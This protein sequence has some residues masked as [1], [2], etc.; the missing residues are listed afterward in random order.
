MLAGHFYTDDLTF[1]TDDSK[2]VIKK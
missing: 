2:I 1:G